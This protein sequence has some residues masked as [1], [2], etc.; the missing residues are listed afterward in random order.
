MFFFLKNLLITVV[1]VMDGAEDMHGTG[2]VFFN[3][4]V[5]DNLRL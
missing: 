5:E 4:A 1:N 3:P 2:F